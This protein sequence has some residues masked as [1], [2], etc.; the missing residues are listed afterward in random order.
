MLQIHISAEFTTETKAI[1]TANETWMKTRQMRKN[2]FS[3]VDKSL[4]IFLY[5][6]FFFNQNYFNDA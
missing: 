1:L 5:Y 2:I 4:Q 6:Y 3:T